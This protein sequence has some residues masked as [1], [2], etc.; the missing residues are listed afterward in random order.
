MISTY[1]V[2]IRTDNACRISGQDSIGMEFNDACIMNQ[3]PELLT[4]PT[5]EHSACIPVMIYM[6][7]EPK[8]YVSTIR[9]ARMRPSNMSTS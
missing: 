6:G 7:F 9:Y 8:P 2:T 4:H 1:D 3:K 5:V